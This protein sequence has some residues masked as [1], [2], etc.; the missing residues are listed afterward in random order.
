MIKNILL[1]DITDSDTHPGDIIIGMNTKLS[2]SSAI[3]RPFVHSVSVLKQVKLGSVLTFRFDRVRLLHMLICHRIGLGGWEN[4]D[5]YVRYCLDYLWQRH[6]DRTYSIVEIG[7]GPV[8]QR[9]G[10]DV[11][12][13]RTAMANSFL[14][15]DL[16]ILPPEAQEARVAAGVLP[17]VPFRVWDMGGGERKIHVN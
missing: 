15:V 11:S 1:G 16:V 10:A 12:T 3:G 13:I 17:M 2:E 14:E 6:G 7:N 4:A 9:D 5:K 8:G